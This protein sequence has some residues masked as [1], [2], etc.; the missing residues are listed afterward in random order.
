MLLQKMKTKLILL[1]LALFVLLFASSRILFPS[2]ILNYIPSFTLNEWSRPHNS[3][4][5]DPVFQFEPWRHYAKERITRGEFPLWNSLNA[6]GA[7]FWANPITAVLS[8]FNLSYY[9]LPIS[10]SLLAIPICKIILFFLFTY[11]Y[12]R[13][14]GTSEIS[15]FLG[16]LLVTTAGVFPFWLLWPQTNVYVLLP[17]FLLFIEKIKSERRVSIW[18]PAIYAVA[19]FGGHPETLFHISILVSIYSFV[20][21]GFNKRLV[22]LILYVL[23]GAGMGAVQLVP[24]LEYLGNS[25]ALVRRTTEVMHFY[26]PIQSA[27]SNIVP[28]IL[29]APH[30]AFYKSFAS[31][32][33]YAEFVSGYVGLIPLF[34][35]LLFLRF[36]NQLAYFWGG[37]LI[38]SI[39][40]AYNIF[41]ASL[42]REFPFIKASADHRVIAFVNFAACVLFA[43]S[44]DSFLKGKI[45]VIEKTKQYFP[46]LILLLVVLYSVTLLIINAVINEQFIE[47]AKYLTLH[48]FIIASALIL[49]V[50]FAIKYKKKKK[51]KYAILISLFI[52]LQSGFLFVTYYPATKVTDYYP[53]TEL[54]NVLLDNAKGRVLEVGNHNLPPNINLI[55]GVEQAENDDAVEVKT[56]R[57]AFDKAFPKKNHLGNVDE[58]EVSTLHLMGITYVVSDYDLNTIKESLQNLHD[59]RI[60]LTRDT[61]IELPF[62]ASEKNLKGFRFITA[63][64]NR[65]NKCNLLISLYDETSRTLVGKTSVDCMDIRDGLFYMVRLEALLQK[66]S[67]YRAVITTENS[68]EDNEIAF[69]G[70]NTKPFAEVLFEKDK[71][72]DL[73]WSKKSVYLFKIQNVNIIENLQKVNV[74][75]DSPEHLSFTYNLEQE[76]KALIKKT[77][78]P[79]WQLTVDGKKAKINEAPYFEFIAPQGKHYVE[80]TYKPI[81][82]YLG[83][84]L[85]GISVLLYCILMLFIN[86]ATIRKAFESLNLRNQINKTE[87]LRVAI[88]SIVVAIIVAVL[89][90]ILLPIKFSPEKSTA[91]NW[92]TVNQYPRQQDPAYFIIGATIVVTI[93]LAIIFI[94]FKRKK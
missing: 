20:R 84:I 28:F 90:L 36:K 37:A 69:L 79:G 11:L 17:L 48:L 12:L 8:P 45:Y 34:F 71:G 51:L 31:Y 33:N 46:L 66:G 35:C 1:G 2:D 25:Y 72:F 50:Y 93:S 85:S 75:G 70:D 77:K 7:P 59:E 65:A 52:F 44:F 16:A 3:L 13:K 26:L 42:L 23:L 92:F 43:M 61:K 88:I 6:G 39:F 15:A 21:I 41:P 67:M 81:S 63:N 14:I 30:T 24:F 74:I 29:G 94:Y 56:Y 55:Y 57:H 87:Y 40:V 73:M 53:K 19:I 38:I 68:D 91:I 49:F 64:F 76:A 22:I 9:V 54:I 80:L 89:T 10:I 86:R 27:A 5:A 47:F 58:V 60:V 62:V 32:T 82:V 78:Y 18:F 4:L 83:V